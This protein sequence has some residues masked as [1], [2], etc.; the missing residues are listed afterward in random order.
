MVELLRTTRDLRD[1]VGS[2]RA[3]GKRIGCVPTMGYLHE[4]HA[5]LMR[6]AHM[7]C[8]FVVVT[9]FVNPTQFGPNEDFERYPR[10]LERDAAIC[11]SVAVDAIFAPDVMEMY[12]ERPLLTT[13]RVAGLTETLCGASRPGHFEGVAT[14]VAKLLNI[15]RPDV[16]YFGQK[17]AQ[18]LAVVRQMVAD[19]NMDF[20]AIRGVPIVR[21]PDG[22]ARSS[23]NVYLTP[24][25]REAAPMLYRSLQMAETRV[26]AGERNMRA[27]AQAM[28]SLI[29]TEP[30]AN[31]D[32][33]EIVDAQTL[34][35]IERLERPALAALAVKFGRTRLID[36]CTLEP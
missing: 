18:Q 10:D 25:E 17:D 3:A 29:G 36:N 7:E 26:R 20:V 23:R 35:P 32:Y 30:L 15:V 16:A 31:I 1:A 27:L 33:V 13:V 4:G 5:T 2:A 24:P 22:L 11:R 19:L 28:R 12:P 9:I 14:V 8:D 21:E 34:Q 6:E